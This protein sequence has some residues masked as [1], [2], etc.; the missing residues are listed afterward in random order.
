MWRTWSEQR[1]FQ[2][3]EAIDSGVVH[4][5]FMENDMDRDAF[6]EC[7]ELNERST[8]ADAVDAVRREIKLDAAVKLE[9]LY[10]LQQ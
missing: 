10:V 2:R 1:L 7:L 9:E 4:V 5:Y 6:T 8:A 3:I